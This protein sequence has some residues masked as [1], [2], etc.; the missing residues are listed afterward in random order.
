MIGVR[1][2]VCDQR[3]RR[4]GAAELAAGLPA[5][6][7]AQ[8][9]MAGDDGVEGAG[10]FEI[11]NAY[12]EVVDVAAASNVGVVNRLDAIAVRIAQEAP[13]V[14]G[15][16]LPA[17]ARRAVVLIA[18]IGSGAPELVDEVSRR[19]HKGNV[20]VRGRR[21]RA[22]GGKDR[23]VVP[24]DPVRPLVARLDPKRTEGVAVKALRRRHVG[25]ADRDAV[26]HRRDRIE[27]PSIPYLVSG[28]N[29]LNGPRVAVGV[30]K[31]DE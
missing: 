2:T 19:S 9:D 5:P 25:N 10:R 21:I 30:A 24:F 26:E 20:Q 7:L 8:A 23:E 15:R 18:G 29:L 4:P 12:P 1:C 17:L 22:V 16:V 11:A 14:A 6:A 31:E 13:V 3:E 27:L 28:G